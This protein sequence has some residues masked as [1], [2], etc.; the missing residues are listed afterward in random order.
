[1][2]VD[3]QVQFQ[4]FH[5]CIAFV[6][7]AAIRTTSRAALSSGF[8]KWLH[9][10]VPLWLS[11][12]VLFITQWWV[13]LSV[14][15]L[16][17]LI[18]TKSSIL[19][20]LTV[21]DDATISVRSDMKWLATLSRWAVPACFVTYVLSFVSIALQVRA[22]YCDAES[23]RCSWHRDL[24][25][26]MQFPRDVAL[27][28]LFMP[29]VYHLMMCR[30][31]L[32]RWAIYAGESEGHTLATHRNTMA[33]DG[34]SS[35]AEMYD[36]YAL[37]CFGNLGMLVA[38]RELRRQTDLGGQS[39]VFNLLQ[40]TLMFGVKA[41]IVTAVLGAL[42]SIGLAFVV[43]NRDPSLCTAHVQATNGTQADANGGGDSGVCTFTQVIYGADF[44]T[45]TIAIYN[46]FSFEHQMSGPLEKFSPSWKFWSMKI[47]V[48][49]SF[50]E[51]ML[52]KLTQPWTGLDEME[53]NIVDTMTKAYFMMLV[54]LLNVIAWRPSEEWY[55][56]EELR[57]DSETHLSCNHEETSS[58]AETTS[59]SGQQDVDESELLGTCADEED[60]EQTGAEKG[61]QKPRS[62]QV[63][64]AVVPSAE[65]FKSVN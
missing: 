36:A 24:K 49:L 43:L 27:Q 31:L 32:R 33:A 12:L 50:S 37:W 41:Y 22:A 1:M 26:V 2:A 9:L 62:W 3:L 39:S 35:L 13:I 11:D 6:C 58:A 45:S 20:I 17:E 55:Y 25:W 14:T 65:R 30:C 64:T 34:D 59:E 54:S 48:T 53:I 16:V 42:Y 15:L 60:H 57:E 46:L 7:L 44:A 28:V 4:A 21:M 8:R 51:L 56:W 63:R 29:M 40:G 10:H 5:L 52:L 38:D 18:L 61:E 23:G 19:R 47:P